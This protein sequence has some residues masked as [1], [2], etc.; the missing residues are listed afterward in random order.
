MIQMS[1]KYANLEAAC[2]GVLNVETLTRF[3]IAMREY[4]EFMGGMRELLRPLT[5]EEAEARAAAQEQ[6][7]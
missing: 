4:E 1:N 3:Q 5:P 7:K 6:A 2:G